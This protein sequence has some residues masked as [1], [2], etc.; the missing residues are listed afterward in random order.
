[1]TSGPRAGQVQAGPGARAQGPI[2]LP[3]PRGASADVGFQH[4]AVEPSEEPL[5]LE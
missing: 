3:A 4:W 2:S 1:M 5:G